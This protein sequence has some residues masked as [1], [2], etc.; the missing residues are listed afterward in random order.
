MRLE[1]LMSQHQQKL[2]ATDWSIYDAV[3][4]LNLNDVT[5]QKVADHVHVSTTTVHRFCKKIGLNG[6]SELLALL[7]HQPKRDTKVNLEELK[8]YYHSLIHYI[9]RYNITSLFNQID[10]SERIYLL[11]R[12]I[13]ELRIAREMVRIFMPIEKLLII[14]PSDKSLV[15]H[16]DHLEDNILFCIEVNSDEDYPTEYKNYSRLNKTYSVL[17]SHKNPYYVKYD[18]HLLLPHLKKMSHRYTQYM[19]T[20]ELLYLKYMLI[21]KGT[22]L[23]KE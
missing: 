10:Q 8:S 4:T 23:Q 18:D 20:I 19:M 6:F 21:H 2:N 13:D 3:T 12:S 22:I 14:L 16:L 5:I 11:I 9:D 15:S 1:D 7:A 17:I